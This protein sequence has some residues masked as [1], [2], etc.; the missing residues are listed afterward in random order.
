MLK[1]LIIILCFIV[2][3]NIAFTNE[4]DFT[5]ELF[6]LESEGLFRYFS[7]DENKAMDAN[8]NFNLGLPTLHLISTDLNLDLS[9]ELGEVRITDFDYTDS[10]FSKI[11]I[12]YGFLFY[13]DI[14][15]GPFA[16]IGLKSINDP[17]LEMNAGIR[18]H[19]MYSLDFIDFAP[20]SARMVNIEVGYSIDENRFFFNIS[21]DP[22]VA[23]A[24]FGFIFAAGEYEEATGEEYDPDE[25]QKDDPYREGFE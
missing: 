23:V 16:N 24:M 2:T 15:L 1:R 13:D 19:S 5:T 8:W 20:V 6:F 4:W 22:V 21:A 12:M 3:S 10:S 14:H 9:L 18:F 7:V 11:G 25:I 17:A